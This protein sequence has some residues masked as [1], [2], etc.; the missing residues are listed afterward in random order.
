MTLATFLDDQIPIGFGVSECSERGM[1]EFVR[2]E[3]H[4]K[5]PDSNEFRLVEELE[6]CSGR[7]R[8]DLAL[9]DELLVGFEIKG[10]KD[11]TSRLPSQAKAYSECFDRVILVVHESLAAKAIPLV[12]DWWGVVV[13]V[14]QGEGLR[15]E[16][17]RS[18]QANPDLN[19]ESLLSLLWKTEIEMLHA[20]LIG[21]PPKPKATKRG[22]RANLL[23]RVTHPVLHRSG[24]RKLRERSE[25]RQALAGHA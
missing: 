17:R 8:V 1:R 23:S 7:A 2:S 20:D 11:K 16:V 12:P 21:E 10:P 6:V 22:I 13:G 4:S 3:V 25:W 24:L 9:I 5:L 19:L 15:Y 18:A 14:Q